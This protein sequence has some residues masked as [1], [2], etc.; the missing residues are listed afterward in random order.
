M[1][2]KEGRS[3]ELLDNLYL[4]GFIAEKIDKMENLNIFNLAP[5]S[6]LKIVELVEDRW[7]VSEVCGTFY[8]YVAFVEHFKYRLGLTYE[9]DPEKVRHFENLF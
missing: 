6:L 7:N 2:D 1:V 5:K 4:R 9:K 8:D 3:F